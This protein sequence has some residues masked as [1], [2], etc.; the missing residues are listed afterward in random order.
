MDT[1]QYTI[2]IRKQDGTYRDAESMHDLQPGETA[3]IEPKTA[4]PAPTIED[5]DLLL[6]MAS[7]FGV[8]VA[9]FVEAAAK[10]FGIPPCM[11][12][13]MTKQ[14]LYSIKHLGVLK[15]TIFL[16]KTFAVRFGAVE[17]KRIQDELEKALGEGGV[18]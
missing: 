1:E 3:I 11:A 12:C 9:D 15:S 17:S 13:Q 16:M 4:D 6:R 5:A 10:Q 18:R 8:Q 14:V 7:F 2:R